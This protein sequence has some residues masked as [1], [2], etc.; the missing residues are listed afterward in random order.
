MMT[1]EVL[2]STINKGV[3]RIIDNLL[4]ER[5]DVKYVVS[6]QYTDERYLELI[7]QKMLERGDVLFSK[8]KGKGLSAN[9]NAALALAT[10]DVV[11]FADD[12]ARFSS[13]GIDII[14]DTFESHPELDVAFF[15]ASTYTGRPLK[16]YP[17][18][19]TDYDSRPVKMEI[20]A[21][22]MACRRTSIQGKLKFDERFGLGN[23]CLT[24]GEQDIW[25]TE[26]ERMGLKMKYFPKKIV[27]TSTMLK[28]RM[29]YVDPSV[30][31][32]YGALLYFRRGSRAYADCFRFAFKA[33]RTGM[34]HFF[35]MFHQMLRGISFL[36]HN[37]RK[38]D[39]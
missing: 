16:D 6:Y 13:E 5:P 15:Q 11:V 21:L 20:S 35:P 33:A 9:R 4:P 25:L 32:S 29:I 36:R 38:N 17:K 7:P 18:E 14:K 2:I 28:Q 8:I 19:E 30:Q 26:A 22:E 37:P 27:E 23:D 10:G 31:R 1:V 24:C 12:D 3:V 39:N 34:S